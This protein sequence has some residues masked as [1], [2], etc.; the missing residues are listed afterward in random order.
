MTEPIIRYNV[1]LGEAVLVT[2]GVIMPKEESSSV[3]WPFIIGVAFI[4][5][6][7]SILYGIN[8]KCKEVSSVSTK[9]TQ[10]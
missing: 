6:A 3:F 8:K 4:I 7:I 5:L 10:R 9:N 2:K 1:N